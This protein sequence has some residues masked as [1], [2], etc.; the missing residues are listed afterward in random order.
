MNVYKLLF[1]NIHELFMYVHKQF[2][3]ISP[4]KFQIICF[5]IT[6]TKKTLHEYLHY[7]QFIV[8]VNLSC[9]VHLNLGTIIGSSFKFSYLAT[10]LTQG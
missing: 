2:M 1:M 10:F 6:S 8:L 4:G 7:L 9:S 5:Q 3:I